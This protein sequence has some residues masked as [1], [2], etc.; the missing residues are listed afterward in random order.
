MGI[1]GRRCAVHLLAAL[2]LLSW[3]PLPAGAEAGRCAL[4]GEAVPSGL[5][6]LY[7][8][9]E[10]NYHSMNLEAVKNPSMDGVAAQINWRDIEPVEGKPDWSQ[11]DA[12]F[13]AAT[14]AKKW[15]HL[16]IFPGF[17]SPAWALEGAQTDEFQI[18]Y[19]PGGGTLARLPMPWDRVYLG[20][21]F[22]FMK[23][24]SARYGASPAFRMIAA[25]GP[26]SVSEETTLPTQPGA[27]EKWL[28]D[29]YTRAK[30]LGAWDEVFRFYAA[31]FPHQCVSVAGLG[32]PLMGPGPKGP[33]VRL[34]A[35]RDFVERAK[36]IV[37]DRLA[38]QSNDL[39]A[40]HAKVEAPDNTAF[41]NSYNGR[42]ITGFEMRSQSQ[43]PDA[44]RVMGAAG[45]PPL[46]LRRSIDKGMAP[47]P[48][49]RHVDY[50]EIYVGD[51][52]P[53]DM[54]PVLSYG[55]SLFHR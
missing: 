32:G 7:A 15:V 43:K 36:R 19:G 22:D 50:L 35:K 24:L 5:V 8:S 17:F 28:H 38:L 54:Q 1:S 52:L 10:R 2:S 29:G 23:R 33:A 51:V 47:N 25:A 9:G 27:R 45:D 18:P 20:R 34:E 53:A 44:S 3:N 41:I 6:V 14:A 39:H 4:T 42:I 48:S 40:G 12:L 55:A 30:Y 21:W 16:E 13:A 26:T 11:L 49:G 31:A 46:A 37:G